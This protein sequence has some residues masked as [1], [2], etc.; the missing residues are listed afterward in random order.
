M[1][2]E[3]RS[4]HKHNFQSLGEELIKNLR[5][6]ECL[7][8]SYSGEESL[9]VRINQ[10]KVRQV[11]EITQA[12]LTMKFISNNRQIESKISLTGNP[13]T[14][15]EQAL[16]V[17]SG[18]RKDCSVLPEDPYVVLPEPGKSSEENHFG[19]LLKEELIGEKLLE[20]AQ[21]LDL[22]GIFTSGVL[23][24]GQMNSE[25]QFHWFTTDTFYFD[26]S[27]YTPSQ[28]AIK[29]T[30]AGSKWNDHDYCNNLDLASRQLKV[31]EKTP[32]K[33]ERGKYRV[34]LAPHATSELVDLLSWGGFSGAAMKQGHSCLK[35]A[36]EGQ[37]ELSSLVSLYEDFTQGV[38]PRF[39]EFGDIA[40]QSLSLIHQGKLQSLLVNRRT[41]KE[42]ELEP[43]GAN[44]SEMARSVSLS[45]GKLKENEILS[46]LGTGLYISNLHYLNYSDR[47]EGRITGMTRYGC[48]WVENGEIVGPIEDMRFDESL[49]HFFGKG[50]EDL[51]DKVSLIPSTHTYR[52]RSLGGVTVPGLLVNDFSLTY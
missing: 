51:T 22:A 19:E 4:Q 16:K 35:K 43:N 26:Y 52:E 6:E 15:R 36:F 21:G 8:L 29:A 47:Q 27:L 18:C 25:G 44:E 10:A 13:Q 38:T 17:L 5:S 32:L 31:C 48:F 28:K 49:Y 2:I 46:Q 24:R 42:Y 45:P 39:N 34:Y 7:T 9:F 3:V 33:I 12:S 11:S 41:A 50:L 1:T 40:P 37:A 23:M 14:D 20:P 30:Y